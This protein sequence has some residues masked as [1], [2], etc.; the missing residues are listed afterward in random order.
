[1]NNPHDSIGN[2]NCNLPA[3]SA[4]PQPTVPPCISHLMVIQAV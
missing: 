4:V 2:E 1:M 3:C